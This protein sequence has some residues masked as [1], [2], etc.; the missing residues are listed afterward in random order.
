VHHPGRHRLKDARPS[1]HWILAMTGAAAIVRNGRLDVL[2]A[3][4]LERALYIA[5]ATGSGV[6][7][8]ASTAKATVRRRRPGYR[9]R[10]RSAICRDGP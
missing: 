2:A 10:R 8:D 7:A 3:N 5:S 6:S 4:Q 1:V 9:L